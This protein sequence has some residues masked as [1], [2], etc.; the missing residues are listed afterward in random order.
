MFDFENTNSPFHI[1]KKYYHKFHTINIIYAWDRNST[2]IL[3]SPIYTTH[4]QCWYMSDFHCNRA[5]ECNDYIHDIGTPG[6]FS[7]PNQVPSINVATLFSSQ[8]SLP[9]VRW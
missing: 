7:L 8:C 5:K 2:P 6:V 9:G 4:W 1:C 3:Y